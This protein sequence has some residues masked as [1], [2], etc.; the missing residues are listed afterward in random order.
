MGMLTTL[1]AVLT[2]DTKGY[3]KGLQTAENKTV[4]FADK[5]GKLGPQVAAAFSVAALVKFSA[6]MA[7]LNKDVDNATRAF[8]RFGDAGLLKDLRESTGG[9]VDELKLMQQAI[10]ATNLNLAAADLPAYF[11]F[12]TIRAA[13]TG[14]EVDHLVESIVTGIGRESR[15]VLDN[16]GISLIALNKEIAKGGTFAEAATRLITR[17]AN[18]SNT[19]IEQATKGTKEFQSAW[20]NL[21]QEIADSGIGEELNDIISNLARIIQILTPNKEGAVFVKKEIEDAIKATEVFIDGT[22]KA[23]DAT[24]KFNTEQL[25]SLNVQ[26]AYHEERLRILKENLETER[27]ITEENNKQNKPTPTTIGGPTITTIDAIGEGFAP[28]PT[29]LARLEKGV[30]LLRDHI[31]A[32][33]DLTDAQY[34]LAGSADLYSGSLIRFQDGVKELTS[35]LINLNVVLEDVM[36]NALQAFANTLVDIVEGKNILQAFSD[37][38]GEMGRMMATYGALLLAQGLAQKAFEGGEAVTKI[39]AGAAMLA[40]GLAVAASGAGINK[41]GAG[42]G[43]SAGGSSYSSSDGYSNSGYDYNREIIMVARGNDL[44]AV[45]NSTEQQQSYL[46]GV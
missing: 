7:D 33:K 30:D 40:L 9:M 31:A 24:S 46:G 12:A 23:I 18:E 17:V 41:S 29:Q 39:V 15:L 20:S 8:L 45:L 5:I 43:T 19:S 27:L 14:M 16:L 11:K 32:T 34:E 42:G 6:V 3:R 44:V 13:E 37:F 1:A 2:L 35:D 21:V 25:T 28:D 38:L 26:L 22:Q 36:T 10:Q 4:L